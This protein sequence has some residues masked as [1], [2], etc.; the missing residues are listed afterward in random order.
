MEQLPLDQIFF[1]NIAN[2]GFIVKLIINAIALFIA[3][4]FLEGVEV[5]GFWAA[6]VVA[7]VL[8]FLNVTV[9]GFLN[10]L[11]GFSQGI[12]GFV[13]DAL[14]IL[15]ASSMMKRFSVKSFLWAF[16]LA[17]VL[18]VLNAVLYRVLF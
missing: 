7:L 12:L 2:A 16:L 14:V 5:E 4:K 13:V 3:A 9:G 8:T 6:I 11:T 1:N 15:L 10:L 17:I 18:T